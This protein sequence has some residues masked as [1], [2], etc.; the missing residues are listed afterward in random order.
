MAAIGKK[1][2][3]RIRR[4]EHLAADNGPGV[5]LMTFYARVLRRQKAL[6]DALPGAG[7]LS[8]ALA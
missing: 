3:R 4:A 6:Y 8:G 7:G 2:E 1:W 5:P